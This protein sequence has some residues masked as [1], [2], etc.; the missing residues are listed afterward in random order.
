[1]F[2]ETEAL[3]TVD[4]LLETYRTPAI[5]LHRPYPPIKFPPVRSRL[6]GRPLLP[7]AFEWPW[8]RRREAPLHFL[9]QIDC[10]EL[11]RIDARLPTAGMLFFFAS[12]DEEQIWSDGAPEDSVRA[13]YA[14]AVAADQ[15]EREPPPELPPIGHQ[16]LGGQY[17]ELYGEPTW[18]LPGEN[19][20]SLHASWPLVALR[21]DSWPDYSAAIETPIFRDVVTRGIGLAEVDEITARRMGAGAQAPVPDGYEEARTALNVIG[22]LYE[23]RVEA[24]RVAAAMAATAL[25]TRTGRTPVWGERADDRFLWPTD[26]RWK[27]QKPFPQA[28]IMIDRIARLLTHCVLT[29]QKNPSCQHADIQ[30]QLRSIEAAARRWIKRAA[31]IGL[32]AAPS[33]KD[34]NQFANWLA[35]LVTSGAAQETTRRPEARTSLL[36]RLSAFTRRRQQNQPLAGAVQSNLQ[37]RLGGELSRILLKAL[38]SSIV[39]AAGAPRAAALIPPNFYND[40][41][42][43]HLPFRQSRD[44]V[45][46]A[47]EDWRLKASIHQMLGH[48]PSAQD[49]AAADSSP[50]LLLQLCWDDAIGMKFGDVGAASFWIKPEHLAERRFDHVWGEVVGH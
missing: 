23:R 47:C 45:E 46:V 40:L 8:S 19:G 48:A 30:E 39:Y 25:P 22:P 12:D 13:I 49:A 11:P 17:P 3:K 33:E 31:T 44:G 32:D 21:I 16:D 7:A 15:P 6:G 50:V 9:A 42:N 4:L 5:M 27:D 37:S 38:S 34:A 41:E 43:D 14:P 18:P 36:A 10:A 28:G 20:P 24:L 1:M 35:E 29:L 26:T 2:P